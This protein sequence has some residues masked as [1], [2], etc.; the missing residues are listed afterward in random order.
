MRGKTI[1]FASL[2]TQSDTDDIFYC[3]PQ[4]QC[5]YENAMLADLL[6]HIPLEDQ[7]ECY[8][9]L[10]PAPLQNPLNL[11][12][13]AQYQ[14]TDNGLLQQHFANPAR[15]PIKTIDGQPLIVHVLDPINNQAD[16]KIAIPTALMNDLLTWYHL[17][18]GHC[19]SK[20]LYDTIRQRFYVPNLSQLCDNFRCENCQAFKLPGKGH[21]HLPPREV[22]VVP[23]E[24]VCV[25]LIGPWHIKIPTHELEFWALTCIDPVTN[26]TE[27]IRIENKTS[28][29]IAQQFRNAW[30]SRYP[31]PVACVYDNGG[32]FTGF[33]F[34]DLLYR[35]AIQPKCITVK[36]PQANAICERMHQT[37]GQV[38]RTIL[39]GQPVPNMQQ[40]HHVIDSALATAM[41]VTRTAVSRSMGISPG[42]LVFHRDMLLNIP[43]F[44]D[45]IALRNK[46]QALVDEATRRENSRRWNFDYA[47]GQLA[48]IKE[49]RPNKLGIQAKGPYPVTRV[50]TNGTVELATSPHVRTRINIRRLIPKR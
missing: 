46:R 41:H 43:V 47:V 23:W 36:N 49:Y 11:A 37:V 40:A 26:L 10:P 38:L 30:L 44:V 14:A 28:E 4:D 20:R 7:P 12:R 35:A 17:I 16:W 50:Y 18:L 6:T 22:R 2:A 31:R 29:H 3:T 33:P 21:G 15:F 1:D 27:L 32:E 34:Q 25:D 8:I 19:G 42:E 13:I 5:L 39:H 24:T 9:N 45:L 48:Y